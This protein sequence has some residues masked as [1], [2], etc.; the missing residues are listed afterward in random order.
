MDTYGAGFAVLWIAFWEC[1]GFMWV[2]GVFNYTK[3]IKR[4]LGFEPNWFW[5]ICWTLVA[6]LFLA[7][8]LIASLVT[9]EEPK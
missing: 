5:K 8:I 9:W 7:T 4:M 1:V 3:D 6:P 2:Y